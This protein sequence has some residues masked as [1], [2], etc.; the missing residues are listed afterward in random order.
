M[1]I[2]ALHLGCHIPACRQITNS[3]CREQSTSKPLVV[4]FCFSFPVEQTGLAAGTLI[5][6]TK[7]FENEGAVGADP[8]QQLQAALQRQGCPVHS[9]CLSGACV[10]ALQLV[11][12]L[13]C[14]EVSVESFG[15]IRYFLC[16]LL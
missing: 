2:R 8:V 13:S 11:G 15:V 3:L 16:W 4:G 1:A 7:S 6:L 10:G 14:R 5:R 12:G 9:I